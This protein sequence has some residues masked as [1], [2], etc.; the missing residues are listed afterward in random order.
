MESRRDIKA[1]KKQEKKE[2]K[3]RARAEKAQAK[4]DKKAEKK[5]GQFAV[6]N[7]T[8]AE[9]ESPPLS[10]AEPERDHESLRAG[11]EEAAGPVRK[12]ETDRFAAS[13]AQPNGTAAAAT[14]EAGPERAPSEPTEPEPEPTPQPVPVAV[15]V[16]PVVPVA[17]PVAVPAETLPQAP[18]PALPGTTDQWSTSNEGEEGGSVLVEPA[19]P[20]PAVPKRSPKRFWGMFGRSSPRDTGK[21]G[22]FEVQKRT[23]ARDTVENGSSDAGPSVQPET[24]QSEPQPGVIPRSSKFQEIL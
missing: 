5:R 11:E 15:P 1:Q 6:V 21:Q 16:V 12:E 2:A 20:T 8:T 18:S 14:P 24:S 13:A 19:E 3:E 7:G 22:S 17:A 9:R 10:R 4:K 23:A